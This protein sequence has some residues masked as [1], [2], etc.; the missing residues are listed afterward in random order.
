MQCITEGGSEGS[1]DCRMRI[2]RRRDFLRAS[3]F[4]MLPTISGNALNNSGRDR[5]YPKSCYDA[6]VGDPGERQRPAEKDINF[7]CFLSRNQ[8]G[9][10][11][12]YEVRNNS[13]GVIG[14]FNRI[15]STRLDGTVRYA[16]ENIYVNYEDGVLDL[17]KM[18][19]PITK[20]LSVSA[21]VLPLITKL[22]NREV[23][24][25][26]LIISEP[27]AECSPLRRA[28]L[29]MSVPGAEIVAA[30]P[31]R[32]KI[33]RF[34]AGL[35]RSKK[36]WQFIPV[37]PA[38]PGVYRLWPPGPA[39]DEQVILTKTFSLLRPV[40]VLQYKFYYSGDKSV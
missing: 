15:Q 16:A 25:E 34:S 7:E 24:R 6:I 39:V 40:D 22:E 4:M 30:S 32:A 17:C 1:P 2:I 21:R 20:G 33:V 28:S 27:I 10:R 3:L 29:A 14:L 18:V 35:F 5:L 23:Y 31:A 26:E 37:S 12:T 19:L 8:S 36:E 13:G 11:M 38:H 9:L